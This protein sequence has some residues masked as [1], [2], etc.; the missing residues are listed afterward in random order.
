MRRF[1]IGDIHGANKALIQCLQRSNFD[2]KNDLLIV[3]GDVSDGWPETNQCFETLLTIK[4]KII[5]LGNHD[6]WTL[7]WAEGDEPDLAWLKVGGQNTINSYPD[8]IPDSHHKILKEARY[9]YE[10]D[11]KL[12]VHAGIYPDYAVK[13]QDAS[14]LLWDRSFFRLAINKH[15]Q[16]N[17]DPLTSYDEVYIGHTP[18]H[19]MGHNEPAKYCEVWLMDTG[20]G[21]GEKLSM[22]DIDTNQ[23]YQSDR[24]MTLYPEGSGRV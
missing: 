3:L 4:N 10:L 21:W 2:K 15:K 18:I 7:S 20:A 6:Y 13:D 17:C 8:G 22:M 16:E 9:Y 14:I 1:V 5:L 11:N 24:V 19:R 23:I 12:F